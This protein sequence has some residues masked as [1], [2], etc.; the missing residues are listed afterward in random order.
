MRA[1]VRRVTRSKS[2]FHR[3]RD[4]PGNNI[5][6]ALY[7]VNEA[8]PVWMHPVQQ[9]QKLQ[10]LATFS[11]NQHKNLV[12]EAGEDDEEDD[13]DEL[14]PLGRAP[15]SPRSRRGRPGTPSTTHSPP[16]IEMVGSNMSHTTTT[17]RWAN[18][19]R[20]RQSQIRRKERNLLV[21]QS[22]IEIVVPPDYDVGSLESPRGRDAIPQ[23]QSLRGHTLSPPTS[24]SS[25]RRV[26]SPTSFL[27]LNSYRL[28]L[29]PLS[30]QRPVT[31]V[32]DLNV[33][34][35]KALLERD[36]DANDRLLDF[37]LLSSNSVSTGKCSTTTGSGSGSG[38]IHRSRTHSAAQ[39]LVVV[40][41][42]RDEPP[43]K[44]G[45]LPR[46]TT[47]TKASTYDAR[48]RK[49]FRD[50]F[51]K[52]KH[53]K[54]RQE[55]IQ[56]PP[57]V[58]PT[59][60]LTAQSI[61]PLRPDPV[62]RAHLLHKIPDDKK[63]HP[64]YHHETHEDGFPGRGRTRSRSWSRSRSTQRERSSSGKQQR[65]AGVNGITNAL[66]CKGKAIDEE[67]EMQA[68]YGE[69][70]AYSQE[71]LSPI[72]T[73]PITTKAAASPRP[74]PA[75][76]PAM[77]L[78]SMM[79]PK[80]APS[81]MVSRLGH[82]VDN[83]EQLASSAKVQTHK[84]QTTKYDRQ[85][86]TQHDVAITVLSDVEEPQLCQIGVPNMTRSINDA[87]AVSN[88]VP[89]QATRSPARPACIQVTPQ[90]KRISDLSTPTGCRNDPSDMYNGGKGTVSSTTEGRTRSL[91]EDSIA[92]LRRTLHKV[93]QDLR[94]ATRSGKR[95]SRK[96]IMA[97]LKKVASRI[98]QPE[99]EE[100]AFELLS[101]AFSRSRGSE[102]FDDIEDDIT[103]GNHTADWFDRNCHK[104]A[105]CLDGVMVPGLTGGFRDRRDDARPPRG[106]SPTSS[107]GDE[108]ELDLDRDNDD[109]LSEFSR[110]LQELEDDDSSKE[111]IPFWDVLTFSAFSP[112]QATAEKQ[113]KQLRK[114][115]RAR[116][117]A[118]AEAAAARVM[119]KR[120]ARRRRSLSPP[121][122][123][124]TV[125]S[126]DTSVS[127]SQESSVPIAEIRHAARRGESVRRGGG[128]AVRELPS[129]GTSRDRYMPNPSAPVPPISTM[130]YVPEEK[131]PNRKKSWWRGNDTR[132]ASNNKAD[133]ETQQ[134]P[135]LQSHSRSSAA[136]RSL[137]PFG[138]GPWEMIRRATSPP[139][140]ELS[141][142]S[143][144]SDQYAR[145]QHHHHH[146]HLKR[147]QSLSGR[148]RR[149][150][151][152]DRLRHRNNN[153][154]NNY[155]HQ[156]QADEYDDDRF[157]RAQQRD[158]Y[159][160]GYRSEDDI[161]GVQQ[162]H[163]SQPSPSPNRRR[164]KSANHVRD[165]SRNRRRGSKKSFVY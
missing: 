4:N 131:E 68:T 41:V 47:T 11:P 82:E 91:G 24:P 77:L 39:P 1:I 121:V 50:R 65:A 152:R 101:A 61:S 126:E 70:Q 60:E 124:E 157:W 110:W 16:I 133:H 53:V 2:P 40:P 55:P 122:S 155:H 98:E 111:S 118:K 112:Q 160:D 130:E 105:A 9:E 149:S 56:T 23:P 76:Q 74:Q 89:L 162:Q 36:E 63:Q 10:N 96:D 29:P 85:K 31:T 18:G 32:R 72:L 26:G 21:G 136:R 51:M 94:E 135:S 140:D 156:Q 141:L 142:S 49:T 86:H 17:P 148:K 159:L 7:K 154:N 87:A 64:S 19:R 66:I 150:T 38:P 14:G 13:E 114:K 146:N 123:P 115:T 104:T 129:R 12:D 43:P 113:K 37:K 127:Y 48:K 138:N 62:S 57:T 5:D 30:S 145:Q 103:E 28:S 161:I 158:S 81:T 143:I 165:R 117:R 99:D 80:L 100:E 42:Q 147:T 58:H 107:Y 151:S 134:Q 92:E 108:T 88:Q 34:R 119:A 59:L 106:I 69:Q 35:S 83:K 52:P 90:I 84:K 6:A 3:K 25:S 15:L 75:S 27:R 54:Q 163:Y 71:V 44:H 79:L 33:S 144:E 109:D 46:A 45:Q 116:E 164:S 128:R 97:K 137:S 125:L 78:E 93:E 102:V 139:E 153:N 132:R 73:S 22:A 20:R 95:V 8:D 120:A 67:L